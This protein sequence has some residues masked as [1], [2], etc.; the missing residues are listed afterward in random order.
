M[1]PFV[2]AAIVCVAVGFVCMFSGY[3]AFR[4]GKPKSLVIGLIIAAFI[5][6]LVLPTI[7]AIMVAV[8]GAGA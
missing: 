8:I 5:A 6:I 1:S 7:F 3:A 4:Y 2:Y